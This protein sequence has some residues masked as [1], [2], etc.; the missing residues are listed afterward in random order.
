MKIAHWRIRLIQWHCW[1][2]QAMMSYSNL[3]RICWP[4]QPYIWQSF[5]W[6]QEPA[7]LSRPQKEMAKLVLDET[8]FLFCP[9]H[10][11]RIVGSAYDPSTHIVDDIS[12][13]VKG[14]FNNLKEAAEGYTKPKWKATS[15]GIEHT[16]VLGIVNNIVLSIRSLQHD[17]KITILTIWS[18]QC[19]PYNTILTLRSLQYDPKNSSQYDP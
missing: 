10:S 13:E 14:H 7:Q 12:N 17:P 11:K 8:Q 3:E 9:A 2:A 5:P 18:Y 4:L 16:S 19:N 15:Q 1:L 6:S